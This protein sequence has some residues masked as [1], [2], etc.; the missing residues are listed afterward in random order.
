MVNAGETLD[1]IG[2]VATSVRLV[3]SADAGPADSAASYALCD[4]TI[5]PSLK[6]CASAA[7]C[8]VQTH[9][10]GCCGAVLYV[11]IARSSVAA[12]MQCEDAWAAHLPACACTSDAKFTED[13]K[14]VG[15]ACAP[16]DAAPPT[17]GA[18]PQVQCVGS[19]ET[20]S[21]RTFSP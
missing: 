20:G 3:V 11:G 10:D 8:T 1:E 6:A 14:C 16:Y 15:N 9:K 12:F 17:P 18:S 4:G 19:G 2:H 7:D 13:G 21:C 5:D